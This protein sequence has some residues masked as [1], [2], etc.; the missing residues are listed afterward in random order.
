MIIGE[1]EMRHGPEGRDQELKPEVEHWSVQIATDWPFG[2]MLAC[3]EAP[4]WT[5]RA[6]A[7]FTTR[8]AAAE[9]ERDVMSAL[10][11]GAADA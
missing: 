9:F 6:E 7:R 2:G 5:V 10:K 8:K 1:A 11:N 4:P 3:P